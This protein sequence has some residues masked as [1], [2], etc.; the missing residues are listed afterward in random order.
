MN[1]I[2]LM[3]GVAATAAFWFL[4]VGLA[5]SLLEKR[6]A[7]DPASGP[8]QTSGT[9]TYDPES[10]AA[11]TDGRVFVRLM[12]GQAYA[13]PAE[14]LL[15]LTGDPGWPDEPYADPEEPIGCPPHPIA[16]HAMRVAYRPVVPPHPDE[17]ADRRWSPG[18]IR[19]ITSLVEDGGPQVVQ[20]MHLNSVQNNCMPAGE[21]GAT[22]RPVIELS[23]M[24]QECEL[25]SPSEPDRPRWGSYIF[26]RPGTHPEH[27]GRRF[28]VLCWP[29]KFPGGPRDCDAR[30]RMPGGLG[31]RYRFSDRHVPPEHMAAFDLQ[32]RAFIESIRTPEYDV[33]YAGR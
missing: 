29:H 31:V 9:I 2:R 18:L 19:L 21:D 17:P 27:E 5:S 33:V 1:T 4:V 15:E 13:P 20:Q 10:C 14:D 7:P 8:G 32:I 28:V 26:A 16:T 3:I 24:L 25:R 6:G 22:P 23:P 12:N 11:E 30:Y